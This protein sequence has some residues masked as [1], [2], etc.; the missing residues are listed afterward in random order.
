IL[1][2]DVATHK[3]LVRPSQGAHIVI[4]KKFLGN[5]DALMIP[6]TSDGRV[7]FGVPWHGKVL[8]GTTDTPLNEH[9]IEP[10]PLEEEIEFI[11]NTANAYLDN[12]PT[13]NDVLSVFAGLRPLAAPTDKD[14]NSTKE[15]SRDHKLIK[16]TSG[17]VTITGGKW[18]TY[19]KMA[20]ETVDM[21][22]SVGG[23]QTKACATTTL[24]IHGYATERRDGHCHVIGSDTDKIHKLVKTD[25]SLGNKLH[26]NF[27]FIEAEVVWA[28][29]NEMIYNIEDF[30]ARRIRFL[31]L[32]A[33]ASLQ[34]AP[35]VAALMAAELHK[36]EN[37]I[38]SQLE[39]Y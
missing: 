37:W 14:S 34:A 30:L 25:S 36:D 8:L 4:D 22:I 12:A 3:N 23:L 2:L 21:A 38:K 7:L 39:M 24:R 20:E 11:L 13:R 5:V 27:D 19:R 6:E 17:L 31:L 18:T 16:S 29:R 35:R 33:K 28:S 1:K 9:Q 26:P 15:I 10:R 32:D